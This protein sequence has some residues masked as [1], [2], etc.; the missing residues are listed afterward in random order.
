M[1]D[2][3]YLPTGSSGIHRGDIYRFRPVPWLAPPVW[4][5]DNVDWT[6][7]RATLRLSDP[8]NTFRDRSRN[9]QEY[10]IAE[11]KLRY[12]IVLYLATPHD[13]SASVIPV[14]SFADHKNPAFLE[15]VR[16]SR[17]PDKVYLPADSDLGI[18]ESYA[19]LSQVQPMNARFLTA[20]AKVGRLSPTFWRAVLVQYGH[21]LTVR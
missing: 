16:Q 4:I 12:V 18:H 7:R 9:N 6:H 10:V 11:A 20:D 17:P 13:L 21:C 3:P 14:Y 8:K 15:A 2:T 5:L 19:D 1:S